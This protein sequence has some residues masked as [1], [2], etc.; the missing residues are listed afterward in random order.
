MGTSRI[1][2][3][4]DDADITNA[5]S[6]VLKTKDYEIATAT[7]SQQ[8]REQLKTARPDLIIL[9]VMMDTLREG[10]IFDRELKKDPE[11]SDIPILMVTAIKE[12]TGIDFKSEAGDPDWL[13]VEAFLDKPIDP[14]VLL[15]KVETLINK[16]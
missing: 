10:F 14:E 3:V 1:L 2:I 8:A 13:P 9:D 7:N 5:M 11:Y 15:E 12:M 4:D 6:I 16:S